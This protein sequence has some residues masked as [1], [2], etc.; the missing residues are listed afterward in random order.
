MQEKVVLFSKTLGKSLFHSQNDWS[1]IVGLASSDFWNCPKKPTKAG[2]K[3]EYLK[4][5]EWQYIA[6]S[7]CKGSQFYSLPL[8]QAVACVY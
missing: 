4:V 5:N 2:H 6:C 8:G 1:F 3:K 7:G